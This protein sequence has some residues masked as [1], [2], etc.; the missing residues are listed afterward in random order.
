[1][2]NEEL[3]RVAVMKDLRVIFSSNLKF[4]DHLTYGINKSKKKLGFILRSSYDFTGSNTI[5]SLFKSLVVS[6]LTYAAQIWS[7]STQQDHYE[8]EKIGHIALRY[9]ALKSGNSLPWLEH[10]YSRL[11]N[12]LINNLYFLTVKQLHLRNDL[13]FIC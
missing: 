8:L 7:S 5:L 9:V 2:D 12:K 10:D 3:T 1:M 4:S 13:C 6:V 11:Y